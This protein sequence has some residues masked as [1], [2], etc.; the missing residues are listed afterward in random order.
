MEILNLATK[1]GS[2]EKIQCG[3]DKLTKENYINI[4]SDYVD[5]SNKKKDLCDF[6]LGY[7]KLLEKK[8]YDFGKTMVRAEYENKTIEELR[9]IAVG[10]SING[11]Y[12]FENCVDNYEI[13]YFIK[14]V[15]VPNDR[16]FDIV[17]EFMTDTLE[18]YCKELAKTQKEKIIDSKKKEL[19]ELK[20]SLKRS[21]ERLVNIMKELEEV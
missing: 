1:M 2:R 14:N 21:Q 13:D 16:R 11:S 7:V 3:I 18:E 10:F 20:I 15:D 9:E 5:R 19:E 17:K 8:L 6:E 12:S 4:F